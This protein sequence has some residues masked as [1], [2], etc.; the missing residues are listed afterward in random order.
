[1]TTHVSNWKKN[2]SCDNYGQFFIPKVANHV[3]L[4]IFVKIHY[5]FSSWYEFYS[6]VVLLKTAS[7]SHF[8]FCYMII[9]LILADIFAFIHLI[10]TCFCLCLICQIW[11]SR[12]PGKW[13]ELKFM[14]DTLV[15]WVHLMA[16][17]RNYFN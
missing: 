16:L 4:V 2:I 14:A 13:L 9:L 7:I 1:M 6:S 15:D 3:C 10:F 12:G 11:F 5:K 8:M 17:C